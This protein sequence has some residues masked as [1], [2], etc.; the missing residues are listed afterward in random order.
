MDPSGVFSTRVQ[1]HRVALV[2]EQ[3]DAPPKENLQKIHASHP[4]TDKLDY[5]L[6]QHLNLSLLLRDYLQRGRLA[7][8][9]HGERRE[10]S[11]LPWRRL[12]LAVEPGRLPP[13]DRLGKD[14]GW[15]GTFTPHL[16]PKTPT[17]LNHLGSLITWIG[18]SHRLRATGEDVFE[19]APM[20]LTTQEVL[21]QGYEGNEIDY[22]VGCE[23]VEL[24]PK[25]VQ[26]SPKERVGRQRKPVVDV[27]S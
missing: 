21:T 13:S 16:D 14:H 18:L 7:H 27:G 25:E 24:C 10:S 20:R 15:K 1:P 4:V 6:D 11:R 23:V 3:L 12:V 5:T 26:K 9:I 2:L 17:H 22:R 19:K 8:S